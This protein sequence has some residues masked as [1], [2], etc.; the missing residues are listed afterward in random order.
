M[1]C[2]VFQIQEYGSGIATKLCECLAQAACQPN[3]TIHM[4]LIVLDI[5][6]DLLSRFGTLTDN[7]ALLNITLPL[8]DSNKVD[9]RKRASVTLGT[10]ATPSNPE[11]LL[12]FLIF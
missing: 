11:N 7:D 12:A 9:L 5:T 1:I 2:C 6:K 10:L 3:T 8:L 4:Q